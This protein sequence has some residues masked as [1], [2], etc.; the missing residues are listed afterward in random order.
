MPF[1][2]NKCRKTISRG[3]FFHSK[4]YYE[5][6]LCMECQRT[7][8][9]KKEKKNAMGQKNDVVSGVNK[10]I[11]GVS[12]VIKESS[13]KKETNFSKWTAEWRK[14]NQLDFSMENKHFFLIGMDLDDFTKKLIR[15]AK[16]TI[17]LAN[18]FIENCYLTEALI[19]SA[20]SST[21]IKIV[22]RKPDA[23]K[24]EC[25]SKLEQNNIP[26]HY[27]NQIHSKIMVVDDSIAVIS[28][29]NFYSGSSGGASK[30]AGVVSMDKQV[31]ESAA[32]YINQ[33]IEALQIV[34][35]PV[36]ARRKYPKNRKQS[37]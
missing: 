34:K 16:K 12:Q 10:I 8:K 28:S 5:I 19:K 37:P 9:P 35:L 31:V 6:P 23:R 21:K 1:Y 30:E 17:L 36:G 29:M 15:M 20:K 3:V 4:K 26:L 33:L 27:D 11:R 14:V 7:V 32:N 22:T 2:C 24:I 18:P 25:H 13:I